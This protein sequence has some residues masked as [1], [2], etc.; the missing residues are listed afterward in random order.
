MSKTFLNTLK[1]KMFYKTK[2]GKLQQNYLVYTN[3]TIKTKKN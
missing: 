1:L 2:I 3:T